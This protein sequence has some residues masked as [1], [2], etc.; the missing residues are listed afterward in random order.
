MVEFLAHNQPELVS[1]VRL[2][3]RETGL[4]E[5]FGVNK[6]IAAALESKV[7]LRSGGYLVINP[8]EAL[9]AI[10]VNTGK[11]VGRDSLEETIFRT[12]LEAVREIVRQIRI[13]DLG[14]IIVIDLIDMEEPAHRDAVFALLEAELERDRSRTR[15]LNISEFG[16]VELTRKRSRSDLLDAAR[17]VLPLLWWQ[18]AG[19]VHRHGVPR[20]APRGARA[21]AP[22]AARRRAPG[23]RASR[24]GGSAR[25][26]R[27]RRPPGARGAGRRQ[28]AA[29]LGL[30]APP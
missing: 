18:R 29:A 27:A 13:R 2:E 8:T 5:R 11:Y 30:A 24:G 16:L 22:L 12:N 9:V 1:R 19:E 25:G 4:F 7:W 10:D 6:E 21:P 3:A 17:P 20:P 14:G 26:R 15:V 23:A 28:G